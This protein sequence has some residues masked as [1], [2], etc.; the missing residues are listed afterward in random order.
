MPETPICDFTM[1]YATPAVV[2]CGLVVSWLVA[3]PLVREKLTEKVPLET[4]LPFASAAVTAPVDC[5]L[6][7]DTIGVGEKA[8]VS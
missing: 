4:A 6:P 1:K 5:E 7:S 3:A 2:V 8:Q